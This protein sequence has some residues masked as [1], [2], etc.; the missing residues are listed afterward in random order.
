VFGGVLITTALVLHISEQARRE[1]LFEDNLDAWKAEAGHSLIMG[2]NSNVTLGYTFVTLN[3]DDDSQ[4]DLRMAEL[5]A[6]LEAGV[7]VIRLAA[8]GDMVFEAENARMFKQEDE[9]DEETAATNA[10]ARIARQK[11]AE[12]LFITRLTD[13]GVDLVIS[14][15]QYSPYLILWASEEEEDN[16]LTWDD[17]I[18]TQQARVRYYART[19]QPTIYEIIND[20]EAYLAYTGLEAPEDDDALMLDIWVAQTER[21]IEIVQEE[22][23]NTRI[24]VT[25][26]LDNDFNQAY[27]ERILALDGVD[28][29]G[30]RVF[31]PQAF[32][33]IEDLIADYGHPADHGK[34]LWIIETWYGYCL[35]PQ[36]SMALDAQWLEMVAAFAAKENI[37]AMLTSDY[38]CFL[39]EG[40]TLFQPADDLNGRTAVWTAWKALIAAQSA[41]D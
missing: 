32:D 6:M 8:S 12:D 16:K 37:N 25:V 4:L 28:Q 15:S 18:Q 11:V 39:Q 3:E 30:L 13:S 41:P 27:Y 31:Q 14:D 22:S 7:S 21:L 5:D 10:T 34:Q 29:I 38:G 40:G 20:P 26:A 33:L 19:Y 23:P 35:A 36:R 9:K 17:F 24:A 2:G 1:S